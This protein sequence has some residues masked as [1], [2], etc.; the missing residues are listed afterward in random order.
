MKKILSFTFIIFLFSACHT[1]LKKEIKIRHCSNNLT[2]LEIDKLP[3]I[4]S[5][6]D[7]D[8]L[9]DLYFD[10]NKNHLKGN[11]KEIN[12]QYFILSTKFDEENLSLTSENKSE[13][14]QNNQLLYTRHKS[15]SDSKE[16]ISEENQYNKENKIVSFGSFSET[17]MSLYSYSY[18][19]SGLISTEKRKIDID[20][21]NINDRKMENE[22][23]STIKNYYYDERNQMTKEISKTLDNQDSCVVKYKYEDSLGKMPYQIIKYNKS[24]SRVST[25]DLSYDNINN[26]LVIRTWRTFLDS[27]VYKNENLKSEII[28]SF[29]DNCKIKSITKVGMWINNMK[30]YAKA[31][32]N[33]NGDL[34]YWSKFIY[35]KS[36]ETDFDLTYLKEFEFKD[37]QEHEGKYYEYTYDKIGN[38][39]ER[40]QGD[41]VVK[42]KIIYR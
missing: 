15:I 37:Q 42:R 41:E 33:E 12:E 40:K 17:Y 27:D 21:K 13:Y 38:W 19:E 24:G 36:S 9:F 28:I 26:N 35:P 10:V 18:L 34:T 25:S 32:Y 39:V 23:W 31:E 16:F 22:T 20:P 29:D 4:K 3:I 5:F 30:Q 6:S 1:E 2:A 14:N 7:Y 11:I 8:E